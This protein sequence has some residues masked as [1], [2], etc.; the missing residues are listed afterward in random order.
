MSEQ[1]ID[2]PEYGFTFGA[3]ETATEWTDRQRLPWLRL[4]ELLT[5]HKTGR[6]EGRCIVPAT[7]AGTAR[8]KEEA[9]QIDVAFLDSDTGVP[10]AEIAAAIARK[11]WS[12]VISSTHSHMSRRTE[13]K[14]SNWDRFFAKNPVSTPEDFLLEEKGYRPDVAK[15]ATTAETIDGRVQIDHRPCP[16]F[17]VVIPL[18][19]PWK[20]SDYPSQ[21]A[22]NAAWKSA[23]EALAEALAL[24]HD[25]SCTDSSR[26]FYL[27]RR[28]SRGAAPETE[29]LDGAPCDIFA[30]VRRPPD[31]LLNGHARHTN[32]HAPSLEAFEYDD[33]ITGELFDLRAWARDHGRTFLIAKML[34]ERRPATLTGLNVENKVHIQCPNDGAHTSSQPD[35]ATFVS[36]AGHGNTKGFVIHCRHAHCTDKDR[37][38]FVHKMLEE[39]WIEIDDLTDQRFHLEPDPL[40]DPDDPGPNPDDE[41]GEPLIEIPRQVATGPAT[42]W[43]APLDIFQTE[44]DTPPVVAEHHVP[45]RLWPFISDTAARMGVDPTTVAIGALVTC[46]AVINDDWRVQPKRHDRTW[47]ESAR[48]WGC[49]VGDP[50]S[51][52]SPVIMACTRIIDRL[53]A[54]SRRQHDADMETYEKNHAAWKKNKDTEDPE[55]KRPKL[56]RYLVEGA[57]MEAFQE[58]LRD[59][60]KAHQRAVAG[61]VL[62]R[63]DEMSE[64]AGNL[65]RYGGGKGGGDRG[66]YLRLYNG[67]RFTVDRIARGSFAVSNWSACF[68]TGCQP[69]PIQKIAKDAA[70]DGLLQ[71]FLYAVPPPAGEGIDREEDQEALD[72]Y[73]A[74]IR[75]MAAV[76]PRSTDNG[77]GHEHLVFHALAHVHREAIDK[78]ARAIAMIP[79]TSNRVRSTL[80]KWPGLFA[81]LAL[82]FHMVEHAGRPQLP[83]VISEE[84]AE[85][86]KNYMLEVALPHLIRADA[87]MF[88][89][90]QTGHARWI[91]GHILAHGLTEIHTRDVVRSYR[92]LRAPEQA[93]ELVATMASLVSVGWLDPKPPRNPLAPVSEWRVNPKVHERFE[94]KAKSET[95]IREGLRDLIRENVAKYAPVGFGN[96][97]VEE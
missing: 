20:A 75:A 8:K 59:D 93:R 28:P 27:P 14:L 56:D 46:A 9:Q 72:A 42:R 97:G 12:A 86:V 53:E 15:G 96:E 64:W 34:R 52:K 57:T 24:P 5:T 50:S 71:R 84:T 49:I 67:G 73:Q 11:G 63:Q 90:Q 68:L 23:V 30:L 10:L 39:R 74:L 3:S 76:H 62:C 55:P 41:P 36:N 32:G 40:W 94:T 69:E 1:G 95:I 92:A 38:F 4:V 51:M 89:T 79:D 87:T 91:A 54:E 61:K 21:A 16:K 45:A 80:G 88:L 33:P 35:G 29:V 60:P 19:R 81:R 83:Y 47:T 65:D 37:L 70:E 58:V 26:L 82:T 43:P 31:D 22:A 25:Q 48:L 85:R 13:A 18:A 44:S 7:F 17:R 66:A 78:A 6:K 2:L 77:Y